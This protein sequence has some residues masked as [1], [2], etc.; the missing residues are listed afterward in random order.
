MYVYIPRR[1]YQVKTHS[2]PWFLAAYDA[3]MIHQNHFFVC[4]N[5]INLLNLK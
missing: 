3:V 5:R 1:K 4:M 2:S